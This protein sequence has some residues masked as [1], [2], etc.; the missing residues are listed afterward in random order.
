MKEIR[1]KLIELEVL[2]SE[3]R[4]ESD[5]P[6]TSKIHSLISEAATLADCYPEE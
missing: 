5:S 2:L 4:E 6:E 3:F 1:D